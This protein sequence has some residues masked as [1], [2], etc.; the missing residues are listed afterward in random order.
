MKQL[1][2]RD[3]ISIMHVKEYYINRVSLKNI[4]TYLKNVIAMT[5]S[6]SVSLQMN[7]ELL[8][9]CDPVEGYPWLSPNS[10]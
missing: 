5:I 10:S 7:A 8:C 3:K 2:N 9:A 6:A 4:V 1:Q